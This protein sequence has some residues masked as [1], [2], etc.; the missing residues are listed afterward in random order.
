M[1]L[2]EREK[3]GVV[4]VTLRLRPD[5]A[6]RIE[7]KRQEVARAMGTPVAR[8][9]ACAIRFQRCTDLLWL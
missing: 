1:L 2:S 5:P 6:G 3:A 9:L 8:D 4:G 7:T